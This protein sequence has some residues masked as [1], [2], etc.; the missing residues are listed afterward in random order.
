MRELNKQIAEEYFKTAKLI[1]RHYYE[2]IEKLQ[3]EWKQKLKELEQKRKELLN[4]YDQYKH[5]IL[6]EYKNKRSSAFKE[7]RK[8]P[9][10][11][12]SD[13]VLASKE[14][15]KFNKYLEE[16]EKA[17][18][19]NLDR[20][21]QWK[22][23][24][25]SKLEELKKR[26]DKYYQNQ[27]SYL[28]H[29]MRRSLKTVAVRIETRKLNEFINKK[30]DELKEAK[31][32]KE[33]EQKLKEL[34]QISKE[35]KIKEL[36]SVVNKIEK[37]YKIFKHA[38]DVRGN[39]VILFDPKTKSTK[40]VTIR[41]KELLENIKEKVSM[42]KINLPE[43][44]NITDIKDS[45][46][47]YSTPV[48][49]SNQ[50]IIDV[51]K[52]EYKG[53]RVLDVFSD[54]E[55]QKVIFK[56]KNTTYEAIYDP[57]TK[58]L[59]IFKEVPVDAQ[60]TNLTQLQ[61]E[62]TIDVSVKH[63]KKQDRTSLRKR[64]LHEYSKLIDIIDT[65]VPKSINKIFESITLGYPPQKSISDVE[66]Q[67]AKEWAKENPFSFATKFTA[68]FVIGAL[69][70]IPSL[71]V[72]ALNP[73]KIPEAIKQAPEGYKRLYEQDKA[74]ALGQITE[75]TISTTLMGKGM[76]DF[77]K[78]RVKV[79]STKPVVKTVRNIDVHKDVPKDFVPL[80]VRDIEF[81]KFKEIFV[82]PKEFLSTYTV[83]TTQIPVNEFLKRFQAVKF[84]D[85]I[86]NLLKHN[87]ESIHASTNWRLFKQHDT[88][89]I[90]ENMPV[91][92]LSFVI[93]TPKNLRTPYV[94]KI[95]F[96]K[97][98]ITLFDTPLLS[99][100]FTIKLNNMYIHKTLVRG[101]TPDIALGIT[102]KVGNKLLTY[103]KSMRGVET[104]SLD[105]IKN[106]R[107]VGIATA[108]QLNQKTIKQFI[109]YLNKREKERFMNVLKEIQ[110]YRK[111]NMRTMLRTLNQILKQQK[112]S[113]TI[114]KSDVL[115]SQSIPN[116]LYVKYRSTKQKVKVKSGTV[117][118]ATK[119]KTRK[120]RDVKN[121]DIKIRKLDDGTFKV[122]LKNKQ[123][124]LKGTRGTV[125]FVVRKGTRYLLVPEAVPVSGSIE[126]FKNNVVSIITT[127]QR[128]VPVKVLKNVIKQIRTGKFKVRGGVRYV[129]VINVHIDRRKNDA[130][131]IDT[132]GY[133]VIPSKTYKLIGST[134][135][136]KRI[137]EDTKKQRIKKR[138]KKK[139]I[140]KLSRARLKT[141]FY[142]KR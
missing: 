3:R 102:F 50:N 122:K 41:D 22:K 131:S 39:T 95:I 42:I 31:T 82:D 73:E 30:F 37:D 11:R 56:H 26:I 59:S 72:L 120:T 117:L 47:Y 48:V 109:K 81:K 107:L 10:I 87:I 21:E 121:V 64:I 63:D 113:R 27:I 16:L 142:K 4:K 18:V 125:W 60:L 92:S 98:K 28:E 19:S 97:S 130:I 55:G 51:I 17:K 84:N 139:K 136:K 53:A 33:F 75:A 67:K 108:V 127:N 134:K 133:T 141:K 103:L 58:K 126:Q 62:K 116:K 57:Q 89:V 5:Q 29:A 90:I 49:G 83:R 111:S 93:R 129:P 8:L 6:E 25:L 140:E 46:L 128:T 35:L 74:Y 101:R 112:A 13:P 123:T 15:H 104:L 2:Q 135:R 76:L 68:G 61:L 71:L 20:L 66:L 100:T 54:L 24:N 91:Q 34:K 110:K 115:V 44:A 78:S 7:K 65:T 124:V 132:S 36:K 118:E 52:K 86:V 32:S 105:V 70:D 99:D 43:N 38:I 79:K 106:N 80:K 96:T 137:E 114:T 94:N 119:R 85:R 138:K 45:I 23:E 1:R 40:K 69:Q 88:P 14:L 9:L 77:I 12:T